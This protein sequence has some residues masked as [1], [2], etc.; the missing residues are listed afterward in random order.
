[1]SA[2]AIE[3]SS[4]GA[5][6]P[7]SPHVG[8]HPF[9]ADAAHISSAPSAFGSLSIAA[10]VVIDL[11][12][13]ASALY[14]ALVLRE[15]YYGERPILWALPWDAE[16]KWLPFLTVVT[17]LVFW[18]AGLYA[19]RERRAGAGRVVSSVLLVTVI[20]LTFAVGTGN[21]RTTFGRY[22][23]AFVPSA[24]L[25]TLMR[26]ATSPRLATSGPT[27][28]GAGRARRPFGAARRC[29]AARSRS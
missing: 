23:I 4:S 22:V 25:I 18:R 28:P 11:S 29:G 5:R 10:L 27:R 17:V 3:A 1:M 9:D 12:A 16:A 15:L 7:P 21:Q 19:S 20:T 14:L 24:L 13:L 2:V 8:G 26:S 6:P